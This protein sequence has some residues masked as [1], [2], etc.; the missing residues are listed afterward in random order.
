MSAVLAPPPHAD[1]RDRLIGVATFA[2]GPFR[3]VEQVF[4]DVPG[5]LETTLGYTGGSTRWPSDARVASG[6]TGHAEAV[7]VEFDP[8]RV[9]YEELLDVF[10]RPHDPTRPRARGRSRH[11]SA[12]FVHSS[13]QQR[14]AAESLEA[15][16]AAT[17]RSVRTEIVRAPHFYR[18]AARLQLV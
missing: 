1:R 4:R 18:A 11:R 9:S 10:W 13:E 8:G 7:R 5:V 17:G 14:A 12:I 15:V 3:H 2:A 16:A 6:R